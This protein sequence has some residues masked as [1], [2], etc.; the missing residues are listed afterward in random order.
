MI[1]WLNITRHGGRGHV[2]PA[3]ASPARMRAGGM[4]SLVLCLL[5]A[6]PAAAQSWSP[7]KSAQV[8]QIVAH[9]RE[10]NGADDATL[11]SLSLS[12]GVGGRM[13]ASKGYGA[14][15]GKPVTG[16]TLYEIGS[17]TKQ[18]TAAAALE[19]IKSGAIAAHSHARL[20]LTTPLSAV[21]GNDPFWKAQPWLTVGRLLTM[22]SNL[23]NFTRRP[24]DGA[25]PWQPISA[26]VLFRDI[27][28]E[29]PSA[30]SDDFDYS[31]T[32]Y[33]L[34][35]ELMEQSV[36]PGKAQPESYHALLR[37]R[38]FEPAGMDE[39]RFIDDKP[40]SFDPDASVWPAKP[41]SAALS[42][43]TATWALPDYGRRRRPAFIH[44]DWLKGSADAVSS[45]VDLFAWDKALMDPKIVPPD[46]RDTLLS[47]QA[48]VSPTT[49]YGMGWF[50]EQKDDAAVYSHS[51]AV[52]GY[53]SYNEI[54]RQKDGRWFSVSIL[55]NSD[56]LDGLSDLADSIAYV[57][58]E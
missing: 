8:D 39:T 37:K 9:F 34:L 36:L 31:N 49:Y 42:D 1:N 4:A 19:L 11:P 52:P 25:D 5:L 47:G 50:Y 54:V 7:S 41:V 32:N 24:P 58:T 35:A 28:K 51:G 18:F 40:A 10:L 57:I 13:V 46:I 55:S 12:I 15:D 30:A 3:Y 56:Q 14:S 44:P 33:F 38:I 27:E 48:R 45:A 6:S 20:A 16:R 2:S 23:P 26:D 53:T 22:R 21:F 17:I 43:Q 29:P